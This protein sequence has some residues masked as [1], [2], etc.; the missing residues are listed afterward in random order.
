MFIRCIQRVNLPDPKCLLRVSTNMP[1]HLYDTAIDCIATGLGSPLLSND[2][3]VIPLLI[4]FGYD[5][6]DAY[7]YGVSA[8]WEPLSIGNSLEQNNLTDIE[9]GKVLNQMVL[10]EKFLKIQS[11]PDV[12]SLYEAYLQDE[13]KR[14]LSNIDQIEWEYDPILT[15]FTG[16]CQEKD[17]DISQG[18][19][20]YNDYGILST[21]LSSAVNSLI[22]IKR[23]CIDEQKYSPEDVQRCIAANYEGYENIL[24]DFSGN[25]DGFG[26]DSDFAAEIT[27][28][29]NS[30]TA[31]FLKNY[32]N[33][34]GGRVKFGLSS[35][36]YIH[37]GNKTGATA[38]GRKSGVPF[39]T[40]ISRDD[41][42]SITQILNF[43][44]KIRYCD[45]S[46]NANVVDIMVQPNLL[47]DNREKF[48]ILLQTAIREG[49]FQIQFNVVSYAQLVDAKAHP[50][51]YPGLIVRVWGFSAYFKD[52]P[53]S[54]QDML[55]DRAK[56]MEGIT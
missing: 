24:K 29:I 8:C 13:V 47:I 14:V 31:E 55:I 22:N 21:G 48:K 52:R 23:F 2:D 26:T 3:V 1:D 56:K 54:Y 50:E 38:D 46:S 36:S 10:S 16:D 43:A 5:Q 53:E 9:F 51:K 18:G 11:F 33:K 6:E 32:R 4:D 20:K 49:V 42:E 17:L 25:S 39:S 12:L 27:N 30:K 19:A 37:F 34:F 35:P 15:L 44:S 40:H 7:D 28:H 45:V 41:N